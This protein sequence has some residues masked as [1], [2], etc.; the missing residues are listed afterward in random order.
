MISCLTFDI[1]PGKYEY[2]FDN[3]EKREHT[4]QGIFIDKYFQIEMQ[5]SAH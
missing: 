3:G 1:S 2:N 4:L 5:C